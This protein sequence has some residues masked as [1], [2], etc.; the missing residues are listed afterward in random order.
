MRSPFFPLTFDIHSIL[1]SGP[2]KTRFQNSHIL[3]A[4]TQCVSCPLKQYCRADLFDHD[5]VIEGARSF[6]MSVLDDGV[7]PSFP[8]PATVIRPNITVDKKGQRHSAFE[9]FLSHKIVSERQERLKICTGAMVQRIDIAKTV[10]GS[11]RAE[12]VT[13]GSKSGDVYR[14][15]ARREVILCAGAISS[16]Q[17]LQLR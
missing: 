8:T 3:N 11:L 5:R 12:G 2:W 16:P 17:I 15:R 10:N 6:G 14:V 13:L 9:A 1:L 7:V 4:T